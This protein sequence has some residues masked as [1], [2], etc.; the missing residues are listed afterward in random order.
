MPP[1][2]FVFDPG[3][4]QGFRES[5]L[6]VFSQ[7]LTDARQAVQ[8]V[9]EVAGRLKTI[10]PEFPQLLVSFGK[11]DGRTALAQGVLVALEDRVPS[12]F[13]LDRRPFRID[14]YLDASRQANEVVGIGKGVSFV[15]VINALA[16]P[17]FGISPCSET[18]H[19]QIPD[20]KNRR[21]A[22]EI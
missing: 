18:V 3:F 12:I 17:A 19:V 2:D 1:D 16:K 6:Q 10:D 9:P 22:A 14:G 21:S 4:G 11:N 5:A 13:Q 8:F 15:K 20:C 7:W